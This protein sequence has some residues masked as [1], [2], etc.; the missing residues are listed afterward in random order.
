MDTPTYDQYRSAVTG[1]ALPLAYL[2][3][4]ALDANIETTRQ[5]AGEL[6]VRIASKSIRCRAVLEY[7]LE[8]PGFRGIM[9]YTGREAAH[10]ASYGFED[11]LVAYPVWHAPEIE[12]V[13]EAI[14]E[15]TRVV[16]TVD[17]SD[18]V[19]RIADVATEHGV[20][21]P[22]CLD[23]DMSTTHLGV[24]FGVRR[25]GI[26]TPETALAL[27][28]TIAD[29]EGVTLTGVLGYEA[30]I[31]GLPDDDPSNNSVTNAVIRGLKRR[32]IPRLRERRA[33]VVEALEGEGY[34][35]A[36]VNG[37]G[38][39]SVAST[40]R[41]EAV[42]ELTVGSGFYAPHLFDHYRGFQYEP[43]V[44][45][46]IEITRQ[47]TDRVYTCRGGGYVASGPP[48]SDKAPIPY[49][50]SGASLLER[51]GAG[52][53]QTPVRYDGSV[54]LSHGDPVFFRHAKAGELCAHFEQLCVLAD[55]EIL[56][57]HPTYRGDGRC[58]V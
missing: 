4:E 40:R 11:L 53:V 27:A 9:C 15:G 41:E 14:A 36:F 56:A 47:P 29:R 34:E 43:A 18:H 22:L 1:E 5:R 39:G 33:S 57:R 48:G 46:A 35:L 20:E 44:G 16:L 10:L 52:E 23:V 49:L 13:C 50:P 21:V 37:G 51:E 58:F 6:P 12:A 38:T 25:S 45:Y 30:Q 2:D 32:S 8:Q 19:D 55:G 7:V 17:S 26:R 31:A 3:R 54:D 42:T 24:H 28:G